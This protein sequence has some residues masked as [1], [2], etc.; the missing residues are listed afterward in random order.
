MG[1][2]GKSFQEHKWLRAGWQNDEWLWGKKENRPV[3]AA[4]FFQT[5][6][7]LSLS[8][9]LSPSLPISPIIHFPWRHCQ[10]MEMQ[11]AQ[12]NVFLFSKA[13]EGK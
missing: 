8:I 2:Q 3:M 4:A 11:I 7:S 5:V 10:H 12:R 1:G 6:F 9:P 13:V